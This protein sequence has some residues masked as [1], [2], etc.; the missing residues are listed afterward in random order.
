MVLEALSARLLIGAILAV[1][2]LGLLFS[3]FQVH[4]GLLIRNPF[5]PPRLGVL[6]RLKSKSSPFTKLW[7]AYRWFY[8]QIIFQSI[9][10]LF[11]RP[12]LSL[13]VLSLAPAA[14]LIIYWGPSIEP[15]LLSTLFYASVIF[16]K[17]FFLAD[18]PLVE[19]NPKLEIHD[20]D[21]IVVKYKVS[22]IGGKLISNLLLSHSIYD[23]DGRWLRGTSTPLNYRRRSPI[24]LSPGETS[25]EFRVPLEKSTG[26]K[27]QFDESNVIE[28]DTPAPIFVENSASPSIG[29]RFLGDREIIRYDP[30]T[31]RVYFDISTSDPDSEPFT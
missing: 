26:F 8:T 27:N 15:L 16:F 6:G 3:Y 22:N 31:D 2:F 12:E 24:S 30:V 10:S 14:I 4:H 13:T 29:H 23:G 1:G 5:S 25:E 17:E 21:E 28:E 11:T 20:D 7:I 19:L 18:Y 9:R